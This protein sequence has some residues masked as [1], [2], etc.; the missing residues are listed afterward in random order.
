LVFVIFFMDLCNAY[1]QDRP[2]DGRL[3]PSI[4]CVG[5]I[6]TS[7]Y[8]GTFFSQQNRF[9]HPCCPCWVTEH[10]SYSYSRCLCM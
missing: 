6:L 4:A 8:T 1:S 2:T 7:H 10:T 9:C 3:M 5:G